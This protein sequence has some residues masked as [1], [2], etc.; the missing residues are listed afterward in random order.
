MKLLINE[1]FWLITAKKKFYYKIKIQNLTT[2][3][4]FYNLSMSLV[5]VI[6]RILSDH[7]KLLWI[8][9]PQHSTMT[10]KLQTEL[11]QV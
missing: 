3:V 10:V 11:Y 7:P 9:W 1:I 6:L 4:P 2:H 5:T 8:P